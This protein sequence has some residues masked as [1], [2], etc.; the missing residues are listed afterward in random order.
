MTHKM[1]VHP[2]VITWLTQH[3]SAG[4]IF[5]HFLHYQFHNVIAPVISRS[6][7]VALFFLPLYW[8]V[9]QG[10]WEWGKKTEVSLCLGDGPRIWGLLSS[11]PPFFLMM[12]HCMRSSF[13]SSELDDSGCG[14]W[15]NP[16][17]HGN[18]Q[19]ISAGCKV[20][21]KMQR[22]VGRVNPAHHLCRLHVEG[23]PLGWAGGL[24]SSLSTAVLCNW[25]F[26]FILTSG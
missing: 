9:N 23:E 24:W 4:R 6:K 16:P 5:K 14:K 1:V 19:S 8:V 15:K 18:R 13:S 17:S 7:A 12:F 21:W 2:L 3:S 10:R 11:T 22:K 25:L 26:S 20:V